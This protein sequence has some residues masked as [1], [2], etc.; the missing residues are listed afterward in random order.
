MN[1][2]PGGSSVT[3][4][5]RGQMQ[6]LLLL[7]RTL[8]LHLLLRYPA[9]SLACAFSQAVYS[10]LPPRGDSSLSSLLMLKLLLLSHSY[11]GDS[12]SLSVRWRP[13]S[14]A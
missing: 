11:P 14:L 2:S 8:T 6:G 13:C 7:A 1:E 12:P 4:L 3:N 5:L 9:P 10:P